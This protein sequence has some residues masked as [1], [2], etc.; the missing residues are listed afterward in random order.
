MSDE[1]E[2]WKSHSMRW[3]LLGPPLRPS[4]EDAEHM[5]RVVRARASRHGA[6]R[7]LILGVTPELAAL[8]WPEGTELMAVD[9]SQR[10]IDQVW[11]GFP[12]GGEGATRAD[13][14]DLP[15][16][17]DSRDLV[18]GDG[19]FTVL[20][21]PEDYRTLVS[22]LRGI[23]RDGGLFAFRTFVR[24]GTVEEPE[25]VFDAAAAGAFDSLHAFKLSL[26]MSHQPDTATGVRTGDVWAS[27]EADGP[28]PEEL[29]DRCGWP[30]ELFS[31]IEAYRGQDTIYS[32]PTVGELRDLLREA[33][34]GEVGCAWPGYELGERCPTLVFSVREG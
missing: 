26:L 15:L 6:P 10:M 29:A 9:R 28:A 14:L 16:D 1:S 2:V 25:A 19:L 18:L 30:L 27:F 33:G 23:L 21:Y 4:P 13:W 8:D 5:N 31:T 11:P 3:E 12:G 17:D 32:F 20:G 22:S 34:F 7:A 24:P